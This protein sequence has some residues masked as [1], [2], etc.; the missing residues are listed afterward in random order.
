M[1]VITLKPNK[2]ALN[3]LLNLKNKGFENFRVNFARNTLEENLSLVHQLKEMGN[4]VFVDLPGEKHRINYQKGIRYLKEHDIVTIKKGCSALDD[5][6]IVTLD[7]DEIFQI[8]KISDIV[9]IGD[10]NALLK[11]ISKTSTQFKLE[12]ISS[13]KLY[14]KAGI[15]IDGNYIYKKHLCSSDKIILSSLDFKEINYLCVSFTDCSDII[16][17]IRDL[18]PETSKTKVI[19]KIESPIGVQNLDA[20]LS[21]SDGIL[22]ARSDLSKFYSREQLSE[23][24]NYFKQ[25]IPDSKILVF[26]SNYFINSIQE[27]I[28]DIEE[29][30]YFIHDYLLEPDYIY[31]NETYYCTDIEN[32]IDIYMKNI[33]LQV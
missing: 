27:K 19:A 23:L 13:G 7:N 6:T 21:V 24:A 32:V 8:I 3:K 2:I 30:R 4:T 12:C 5:E 29:V 18:Y 25:H 11:V 17:E 15:T 1:F 26:A 20:I 28:Y 31:I 14:N 33:N 9:K 22:L 10:S 16:L